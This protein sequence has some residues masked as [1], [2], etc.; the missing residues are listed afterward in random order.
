M[1]E[2]LEEFLHYFLTLF[3][4]EFSM[5]FPE[6]FLDKSLLKPPKKYLN[7]QMENSLKKPMA[8]YWRILEI[9]SLK[10]IP[11]ENTEEIPGETSDEFVKRIP[12]RICTVIPGGI[13]E[14]NHR[15]LPKKSWWGSEGRPEE[16]SIQNSWKNFW[17][18][19]R[20]SF[21]QI[22]R[23]YS[24]MFWRNQWIILE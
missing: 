12:R 21:W 3:M 1:Y 5:K 13:L 10:N 24:W 11:V 23:P 14:G 8:K 17:I 16:I 15:I 9:I 19:S 22:S 18:N 2:P 6:Q 7:E 4:W 20:R